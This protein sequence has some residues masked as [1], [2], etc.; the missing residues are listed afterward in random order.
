MVLIRPRALL[1]LMT[2]L[3]LAGSTQAAATRSAR[4]P[5][6]HVVARGETLWEVAGRLGVSVA[7]LAR[8]NRIADPDRIQIGRRLVVPGPAASGRSRRAPATG[9]GAG[10]VGPGR[11]GAGRERT[12][13]RGLASRRSPEQLR[14][15]PARL[16]L[17]PRF[18]AS[19]RE[20]G[21]PADLLKAVAWQESGWQNHKVSSTKALGIGQLMPDTVTFV[22]ERLLRRQLDPRRPEHNIAMSARFLRYLLDSTN[23][24][25]AV[26]VA[27]YYQGLASVRRDGT[28][29]VTDQYV[30]N[31][32]A[33]RAKF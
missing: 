18:D 17:A 25:V 30:A 28:L 21:V 1:A 23:G 20:H 5:V 7:D 4:R 10:G 6:P 14:R 33:L 2:L 31:V 8:A 16:A 32:L 29:R 3:A 15:E 9:V 27:A 24:N 12:P 19:A 22:N 11:V 13:E 26:A